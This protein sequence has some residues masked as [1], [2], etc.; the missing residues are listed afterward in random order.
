MLS[1]SLSRNS[2]IYVRLSASTCFVCHVDF[3]TGLFHPRVASPDTRLDIVDPLS[4][5]SSPTL[6]HP[7]DP[8]RSQRSSVLWKRPGLAPA[9]T[10]VIRSSRNSSVIDDSLPFCA[11]KLEVSIWLSRCPLLPQSRIVSRVRGCKKGNSLP[12]HGVFVEQHALSFF[13]FNSL[14]HLYF[15]DEMGYLTH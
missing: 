10:S 1:T 13:F 12:G 4:P 9:Y 11:C 14:A 2:T 6:E 8:G 7:G 5:I 3:A 15:D